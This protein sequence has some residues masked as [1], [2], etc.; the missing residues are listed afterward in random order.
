M[1]GFRK[2]IAQQEEGALSREDMKVLGDLI[3][4]AHD[5]RVAMNNATS[6]MHSAAT[7]NARGGVAMILQGLNTLK[8]GE[9]THSNR[10][11]IIAGGMKQ[12]EEQLQA[13][14]PE[15]R[16]CS[17]AFRAALEKFRDATSLDLLD[18]TRLITI[19]RER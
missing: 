2:K 18:E 13:L 17:D 1:L 6:D 10:L 14:P 16:D 8:G 5:F 19:S 4:A 7:M 9:P 3:K 12:T 11:S 15:A